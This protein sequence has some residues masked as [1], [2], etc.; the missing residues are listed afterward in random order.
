MR[1]QKGRKALVILSDGVDTG[2]KVSLSSAVEAAQRADTLVYSVLFEDRDAYGSPGGFGGMGRGGRGRGR[3]P[4]PSAAPVNGK[5]VLERISTE[6][7][8]RFFEVSKKEPLEKIYQEIE[9][10]LRHQYSMGYTPTEHAAG[11]RKIHLTTKQKGLTVQTR[12]G[13]Y[14]T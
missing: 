3:Y 1:K 11:Y 8:G 10:D 4:M 5:K 13:Y 9:E 6:T 14:A 2:S 7:G 12:E